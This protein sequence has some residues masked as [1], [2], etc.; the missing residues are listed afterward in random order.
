MQGFESVEHELEAR[1]QDL[2]RELAAV[3]G[4]MGEI[5]ADLERVHDAMEALSGAKKKPK[6]K[7]AKKPVPT[8]DEL[9]AHIVHVREHNPFAD[10]G[11]LEKAVRAR[12]QEHGGSLSG[13]KRTFAEALLTSPGHHGSSSASHP[14]SHP[15]THAEAHRG[16]AL[17]DPFAHRNG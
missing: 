9:R 16:L 1:R 17:G 15:Q 13:F 11:T 4:R 8:V 14:E 10:A 5:E 7:R 3:R 2:E 6:A 12:I